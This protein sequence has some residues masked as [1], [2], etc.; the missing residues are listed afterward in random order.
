MSE[1]PRIAGLAPH[2][3]QLEAG[4]NYAFCTCGHSASQPLC[5]GAHKGTS[6]RPNVFVAEQDEVVSMCLCKHTQAGYKCDGTHKGL[7]E[8]A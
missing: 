7:K 3:M 6:F 8:Q 4:K 1:Q 5:D 2:K